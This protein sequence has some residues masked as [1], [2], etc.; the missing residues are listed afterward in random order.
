MSLPRKYEAVKIALENGP[1]LNLAL[2]FVTQRLTDYEVLM[3]NS[4]NID[5]TYFGKS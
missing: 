5:K 3:G 1:R 2:E 4:K